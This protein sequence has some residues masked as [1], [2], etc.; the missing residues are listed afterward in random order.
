MG[1]KVIHKRMETAAGVA[2][3]PR[4]PR[5]PAITLANIKAAPIARGPARR[6]APEKI[7]FDEPANC[8][9]LDPVD[10][11][12][13]R[14]AFFRP[15]SS[16]DVFQGILRYIFFK[17]NNRYNLTEI[18]FGYRSQSPNSDAASVLDPRTPTVFRSGLSDWEFL[19]VQ[20]LRIRVRPTSYA[21]RTGP[22]LRS[23]PK[24]SSFV[25]QAED[26][27]GQW[28]TLDERHYPYD[29]PQHFAV[30][31][32]YVDTDESFTHFRIRITRG[33]CFALSGF[34]IHGSVTVR[35]ECLPRMDQGDTL[36]DDEE[37]DPYDLPEFD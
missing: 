9:G 3:R 12:D 16:E 29:T 31:I 13:Y 33:N 35:E 32:Y 1:Q 10:Y 34:E 26:E 7:N 28:I 20:F 24:I 14:P 17:S 11:S 4:R 27:D 5:T 6:P 2:R 37:F 8:R 18:R 19:S 15:I 36:T 22:N 30:R 21:F 25:F 23:G